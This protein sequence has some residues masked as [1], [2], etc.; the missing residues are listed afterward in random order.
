MTRVRYPRENEKFGP[1]EVPDAGWYDAVCVDVIDDGIVET[2]FG[3]K[4]AV[5]LVFQLGETKK[6][7]TR[8]L[9]FH[10][11]WFRVSEEGDAILSSSSITQLTTW[12]GKRAVESMTD[13]DSLMGKSAKV[14][15]VHR[16]NKDQ[17]YV[18][19]SD[20]EVPDT[21]LKPE[22]YIRPERKAKDETS[23]EN[24]GEDGTPF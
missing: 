20:I 4:P 19:I 14:K 12:Q 6:N 17:V 23:Q 1:R 5:T 2:R 18:N 15:V 21:E 22:P 24:G 13:T 8:F 9:V 16:R 3:K 10:R 11:L 7:G